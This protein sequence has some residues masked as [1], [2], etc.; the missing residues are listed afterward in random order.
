M[1]HAAAGAVFGWQEAGEHVGWQTGLRVHR[2]EGR[3][4]F[5]CAEVKPCLDL[6][7]EG[8]AI[9]GHRYRRRVVLAVRWH[10]DEGVAKCNLGQPE[11]TPAK[12]RAE[13]ICD[14]HLLRRCGGRLF[15][16]KVD[17]VR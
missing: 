11:G 9:V 4:D 14:N 10:T 17:S 3:G 2:I 7:L 8:L 6:H 5:A 15:V 12:I 13:V 1:T 16:L